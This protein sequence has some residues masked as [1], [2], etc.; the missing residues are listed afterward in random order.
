[1]PVADEFAP[2]LQQFI[3]SL[4][5][6]TI[7]CEI[8]MSDDRF[9]KK[10]D[11]QRIQIEGTV[12]PHRWQ[13]RHEQQCGGFRFRDGSQLNGVRVD[14]AKAQIMTVLKK[15]VQVNNVDD[16]KAAIAD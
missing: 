3:A 8:D 2:H 10:E 5:E 9:G 15:R 12:H 7:R 6:E 1:M 11:P 14:E 16:F 13:G 4:K